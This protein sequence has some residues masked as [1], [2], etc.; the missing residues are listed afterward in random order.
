MTVSALGPSSARP[1]STLI[2]R[3]SSARYWPGP[4]RGHRSPKRSEAKTGLATT[5]SLRALLRIHTT[6]QERPLVRYRTTEP[7]HGGSVAFVVS[8][9]IPTSNRVLGFANT[10]R[11]SS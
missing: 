1:T 2:E 6:G 9:K 10:L 4:V 11:N 8:E 3:G 7:F 5:G